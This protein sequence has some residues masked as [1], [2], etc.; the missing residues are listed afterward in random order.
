[1]REQVERAQPRR[2]PRLLE[3]DLPSDLADELPLAVPLTE[4]PG[5]EEK[6]AHADERNVVG[7]R[8]AGGRQLDPLLAK[9]L[10]HQ[11]GRLDPCVEADGHH[12]DRIA[13]LGAGPSSRGLRLHSE[14]NR[15]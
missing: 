9:T 1:M 11:T 12:V 10:L 2:L 14:A 8:C 6:L 5:E 13:R 4:L 7:P 15:S 3:A